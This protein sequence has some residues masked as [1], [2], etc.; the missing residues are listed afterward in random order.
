MKDWNLIIKQSQKIH[1]AACNGKILCGMDEAKNADKVV[2]ALQKIA[3]SLGYRI[4]K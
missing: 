1:T 2:T 4:L 3:S